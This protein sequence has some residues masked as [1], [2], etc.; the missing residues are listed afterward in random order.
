MRDVDTGKD[1]PDLI[2]WV[3]FSG[4]SWSKDGKGFLLQPL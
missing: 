3:K 1:L 2:K 4:A